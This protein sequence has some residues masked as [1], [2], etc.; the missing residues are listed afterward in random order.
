MTMQ[1]PWV[2]I[3]RRALGFGFAIVLGIASLSPQSARGANPGNPAEL[4]ATADVKIL[5]LITIT[6]D[7][8]LDFGKIIPPSA[9]SQ[10]FTVDTDNNMTPGPGIGGPGDGQAVGGHSRGRY[11]ITGTAG[12]PYTL[13]IGSDGCTDPTNLIFSNLEHNGGFSPVLPQ[14]DLHIG[15]RLEVNNSIAPGSYTCEYFIKAEY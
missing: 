10:R 4:A 7:F 12:E 1:I 13:T 11:Q 8:N 3:N 2:L 9:G 14:V 6:E 5:S 15:G